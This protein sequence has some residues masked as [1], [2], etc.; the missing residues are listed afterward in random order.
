M[1]TAIDNLERS[2]DYPAE[3]AETELGFR[4]R[5]PDET[6]ADTIGRLKRKGRLS[7]RSRRIVARGKIPAG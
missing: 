7:E 2:N 6:T 1:E 3:R 5:P 4:S